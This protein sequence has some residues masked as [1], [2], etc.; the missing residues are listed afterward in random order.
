MI[1]AR[2]VAYRLSHVFDLFP[3]KLWIHR[4][5]KDLS[6]GFL[7][8]RQRDVAI[9]KL[10]VNGLPVHRDW[11]MYA[12]VDS[13]CFQLGKQVVTSSC[14]DYIKMIDVTNIFRFERRLDAGV[15]QQL[16]VKP[17]V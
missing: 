5:R 9:S 17:S 3:T 1:S 12:G 14:P 8:D 7:S 11:I 6:G 16:V 13:F 4:Q 2:C 15:R 10:Q